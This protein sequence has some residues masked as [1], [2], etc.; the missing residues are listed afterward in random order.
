M[1][2]IERFR[3][4][5]LFILADLLV[6]IFVMALTGWPFNMALVTVTVLFILVYL[7]IR[8]A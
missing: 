7:L 5:L 6:T 1:L 8:Y 4:G 2:D 3:N